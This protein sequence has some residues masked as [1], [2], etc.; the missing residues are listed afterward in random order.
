MPGAVSPWSGIPTSASR[1]FSSVS[2]ASGWW[3]PIIL[4][5]RWKWPGEQRAALPG[6]TLIDTPGVI[7]FPPYSEDEQVTARLLLN[8]PL[9]VILQVGDAKNLRRTLLLTVQLAEMG[10]PLVL[11]LNMTDE[12]QARGVA[13]D[14]QQL[15]E[16][17]G[18]PVIPTTAIHGQGV[19]QLTEAVRSAHPCAFRT[20]VSPRNRN[21]PG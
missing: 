13:L 20:S 10:L 16:S 1:S 17:I 11:A 8:E 19:D 5:R 4:G 2:P 7:A 14:Y 21:C 18:A 15:S 9:Q 6:F 3:S 12:A